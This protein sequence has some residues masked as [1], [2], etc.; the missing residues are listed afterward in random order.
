[1]TKNEGWQPA[2]EFARDESNAIYTPS[3]VTGEAQFYIDTYLQHIQDNGTRPPDYLLMYGYNNRAI[4]FEGIY[5]DLSGGGRVWFDQTAKGLQQM[6]VD[7]LIINPGLAMSQ[8]RFRAFAFDSHVGVYLE[9]GLMQ[10][11]PF[12]DLFRIGNAP[13]YSDSIFDL[14]GLRQINQ[15]VTILFPILKLDPGAEHTYRRFGEW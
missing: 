13:P 1:M 6:I 7:E 10:Q 14:D 2:N 15:I 8:S 12:M 5:S 11:L 4:H 9:G 3:D